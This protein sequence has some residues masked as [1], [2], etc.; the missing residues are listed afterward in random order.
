MTN[1][2]NSELVNTVLQLLTEAGSGAF[3][4]SIRLL[5]NEAMRQERAQAL[6]AQPYERTDARLGMPT[7]SSP[8]PSPP[9]AAPS[10]SKFP[11]CAGI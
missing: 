9:A 5:V 1:P 2:G 7:A 11:K 10:S 8:K 4:E 6:Q 3:A